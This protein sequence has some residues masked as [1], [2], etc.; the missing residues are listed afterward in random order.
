[1][2]KPAV[3]LAVAL[4]LFIGT[5]SFASSSEPTEPFVPGNRYDPNYRQYVIDYFGP[6]VKAA[7]AGTGIYPSVAMAQLILETGWVTSTLAL[8]Y[9]NLFGIKATASW[10]GAVSPPLYDAAEG[11]NDRYRAY[12]SYADSIRDHNAVLMLNRY[13]DARSADNPDLQ[14]YRLWVAGY[15]TDSQYPIKLAT[16]MTDYDLYRFDS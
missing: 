16:L 3:I 11:S 7:V 8:Q 5:Q 2:K 6:I 9:K 10:T 12:P 15:A 4:L 13:A 14:A 1:M